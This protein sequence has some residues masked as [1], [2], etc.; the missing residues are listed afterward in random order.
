MKELDE[1]AYPF[2]GGEN[3]GHR[4]HSGMTLRDHF[5]GLAMQAFISTA[6]APCLNGLDGFEP[7]TAKAAYKLAD[8]MLEER[9]K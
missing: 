9:K 8:A 5:A 4:P 2:E 6:A 7:Y 1:L 3:N